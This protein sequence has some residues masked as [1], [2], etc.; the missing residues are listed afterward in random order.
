MRIPCSIRSG[1]KKALRRNVS[2]LGS[3]KKIPIPVPRTSAGR[4]MARGLDFGRGPAWGSSFKM[5][6]V[7][8]GGKMR[9]TFDEQNDEVLFPTVDYNHHPAKLFLE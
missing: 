4:S 7:K 8:R 9:R 3:I 1:I 2:G 5:E 6:G